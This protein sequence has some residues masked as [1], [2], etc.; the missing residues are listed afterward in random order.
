MNRNS[1]IALALACFAVPAAAQEREWSFDASEDEAF[2]IFGVPESD[3][4][5]ISFWCT[6]RSG[7]V[8][9]FIPEASEKLPINQPAKF[10]IL[11]GGKTFSL[12]G[13]TMPNEEAGTTS[14]EGTVAV[15]DPLF[16][17]LKSADR[18]SAKIL[19]QEQTFPLAGADLQGLLDSCTKS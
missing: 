14:I 10:D 6:L 1:L 5:G 2:M 7:E 3:D 16:T 12:S 17:A 11:A 19:D 18:F 15:T 4:V 13:N 9:L 8:R